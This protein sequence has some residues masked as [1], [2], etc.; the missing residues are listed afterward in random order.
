MTSES[1]VKVTRITVQCQFTL[2]FQVAL[3]QIDRQIY[4]MQIQASRTGTD[5]SQ[6]TFRGAY[7]ICTQKFL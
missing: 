7:C 1:L 6:K 3:A 4:P 5:I 2:Q